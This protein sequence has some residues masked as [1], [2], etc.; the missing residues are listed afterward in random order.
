MAA[1]NLNRVLKRA[2]EHIKATKWISLATVL[3][4]FLSFTVSGIVLFL[5]VSL[6][7]TVSEF[8][9]RPRIYVYFEPSA[10]EEDILEIK[11]VLEKNQLIE[12]I[13]YVSQEQAAEELKKR[14]GTDTDVKINDMVSLLPPSLNVQPASLDDVETVVAEIGELLDGN[15]IVDEIRYSADAIRNLQAISAIVTVNGY[16]IVGLAVAV[17]ILLVYVAINF[18]VKY[19]TE[20]LKIMNVLGSN[21]NMLTLPFIVEA[22]LYGVVGGALAGIAM[23]VFV[24]GNKSYIYNDEVLRSFV[25]VNNLSGQFSN[26]TTSEFLSTVGVAV[27]IGVVVGFLICG[28]SGSIAVVGNLK[29][30]KKGKR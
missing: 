26:V 19:Y 6:Q 16:M 10:E 25:S 17:S 30:V 29:Y 28:I 7:K 21:K 8:S 27:G 3:V 22:L 5:T 12:S 1:T 15:P 11:S 9:S 18:A 14:L 13:D 23:T 20:E 4:I 2:F 24:L